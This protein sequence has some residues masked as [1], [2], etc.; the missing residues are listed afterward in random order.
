[1]LILRIMRKIILTTLIAATFCFG[2][3]DT[4][5][6]CACSPSNTTQSAL[7]RADA[8]F[9]GKVIESKK[10]L[11][12]DAKGYDLVI[13]FEVKQAWKQNLKRFIFVKESYGTVSGFEQN[14]EWLL[15]AYADSNGTF[16]IFRGC[17]SRTKPLS[18]VENS[19]N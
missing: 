16:K 19:G 4:F 9:V 10:F 7:Q 11:R 14:A 13:K 3:Y 1:M 2:A 18:M 12:E 17:C 5:A 6:Q 15:Y 8:V